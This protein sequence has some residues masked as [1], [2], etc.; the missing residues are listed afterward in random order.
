MGEF[1]LRG[2][3]LDI[4]RYIP[5]T[6]PASEPFVLPTAA[7]KALMFRG[8]VELERAT[9]DDIEMKGVTLRLL[10]DE[11]GLRSV[12]KPEASR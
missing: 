11:N 10:L 5:P 6:D 8:S 3:V 12:A 4:A 1:A 9:F 2:D 7:L